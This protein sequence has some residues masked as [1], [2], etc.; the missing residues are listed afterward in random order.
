MWVCPSLGWS[1]TT[2]G[3][4]AVEQ[5]PD[6]TAAWASASRA[7]WSTERC[8]TLVALH[9]TAEPIYW[10]RSLRLGTSAARRVVPVE[11]L[12]PAVCAVLVEDVV[13]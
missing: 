1:V 4:Q 12:P 13:V 11:P 3:S 8:L 10:S 7:M 5:Q 9:R 2:C 6:P